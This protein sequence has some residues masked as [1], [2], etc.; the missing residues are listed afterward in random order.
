MNAIDTNVLVY[1]ADAD[2][3]AKRLRALALLER[4]GLSDTILPWQVVCETAAVLTKLKDKDRTSDKPLSFV[5]QLTTRFPVVRPRED[6]VRRAL[7]LRQSH[8][9]SFWDSL[10]LV[11]CADAKVTRLYSEDMQGRPVIE[12]VGII[13]P[14]ARGQHWIR[15]GHQEP[16]HDALD[17]DPH[18]VADRLRRAVPPGQARHG[19]VG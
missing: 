5:T 11:A 13:D 10:L 19:Q 14:F 8:Q 15:S 3:P 1:A 2:S 18:V 4:L 9:M 7:A 12:G 17:A 6:F 16:R